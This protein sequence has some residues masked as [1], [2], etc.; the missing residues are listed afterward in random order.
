MIDQPPLTLTRP[1][2]FRFTA[3]L[4]FLASCA[5]YKQNIMFRVMDTEVARQQAAEAESGYVV[6]KND[7]LLVDVFTNKGERI[8]DPNVERADGGQAVGTREQAGENYPVDVNGTIKLPLLGAVKLEG[9]TLR[10]AEEILQQEYSRYYQDPFVTIQ[11]VNKRVVVLGSPGGRVIPLV[12]ENTR[13][14]ELLA[15]AEG[16]DTDAR[17]NNIRVLRGQQVFVVDFSTVDGYLKNDMILRP[18]DIIYVEPVRR[19]FSEGLRDYGPILS[20]IT[21]VGTLIIVILQ[22]N[23]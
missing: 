19:P 13:L 21:S 23:P 11:F 22:S 4:F 2:Y 1:H 9:L 15:L 6:R 12:N 20:V 7:V 16:L 18:G 5:S 3:L 8:L 10:Q 14:T 17:S